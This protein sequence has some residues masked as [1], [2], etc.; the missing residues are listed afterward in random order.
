MNPDLLLPIV[1]S[2]AWLILAGVGLASFQLKW[3]QML[4]MAL[5]W[6]VIFGAVFLAVEWFMIAQDTTSALI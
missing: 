4:K 3:S 1:A 6:I 2:L 5:L